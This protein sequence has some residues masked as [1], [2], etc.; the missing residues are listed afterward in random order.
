MRVAIQVNPTLVGTAAGAVE[1][2][3]GDIALARA[4]REVIVYP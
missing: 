2:R 4:E 3:D 1:L